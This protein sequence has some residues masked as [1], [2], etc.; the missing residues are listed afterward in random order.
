MLVDGAGAVF[1]TRQGKGQETDVADG[2][3][4]PGHQPV[5]ALD[6]GGGHGNCAEYSEQPAGCSAE[7]CAPA[8]GRACKCRGK[9]EQE[10]HSNLNFGISA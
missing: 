10:E 7:R 9:L 3:R 5:P 2:T 6:V 8:T 1:A 4:L